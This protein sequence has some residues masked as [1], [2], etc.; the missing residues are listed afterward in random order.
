MKKDKAKVD[1]KAA[2]AVSKLIHS[3][4][5]KLRT[6]IVFNLEERI[7]LYEEFLTEHKLMKEHPKALRNVRKH[8]KRVLS[9]LKFQTKLVVPGYRDQAAEEALRR[10]FNLYTLNGRVP[11]K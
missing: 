2:R 8:L 6:T 5:N 3:E 10:Q 11:G 4:F 1:K 9:D 7:K